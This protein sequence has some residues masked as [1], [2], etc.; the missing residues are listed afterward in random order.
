MMGLDAL[1]DVELINS[2]AFDH[3]DELLALVEGGVLDTELY[4]SPTGIAT[5]SVT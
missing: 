1:F 4:A 5:N 3:E 2:F